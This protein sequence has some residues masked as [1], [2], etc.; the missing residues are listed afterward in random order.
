MDLAGPIIA[1][2]KPREIDREGGVLPAAG[3][4]G[5][6]VDEAQG[7]QRLYERQLAAVK[8]AELLEG[9]HG[10]RSCLLPIEYAKPFNLASNMTLA[11]VFIV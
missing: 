1:R 8:R 11:G 5:A 3:Q 10:V 4:P 9:K 7:A 6:V 2:A